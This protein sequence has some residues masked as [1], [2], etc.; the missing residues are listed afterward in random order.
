M[1]RFLILAALALLAS[2]AFASTTAVITPGNG[3]IADSHNN[4]FSI[5]KSGTAIENGKN[6]AGG[7][8][9]GKMVI[10]DDTVYGQDANSGTWYTWN[11]SGWSQAASAP[12][13][14]PTPP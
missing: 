14:T 2:P 13:L 1:R 12:D 11:G 6:M 9:T 3:T 8:G 7:G 5:D 10:V 4:L